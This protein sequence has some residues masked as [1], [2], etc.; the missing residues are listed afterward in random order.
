M[1]LAPDQSFF[2]RENLKL[3]LLNAR[4]GLLA[5][6]KASSQADLIAIEAALNRYFDAGSPVVRGALVAVG[7]IREDI[8]QGDLPRPDETLAALN[9]AAGG[10]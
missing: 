9:V 3:K 1:L 8:R 10:R 4:L 7:Q 6:H 5:R 2:I